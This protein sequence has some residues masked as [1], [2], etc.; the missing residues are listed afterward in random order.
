[1]GKV[2]EPK[3]SYSFCRV[4]QSITTGIPIEV[5]VRRLANPYTVQDQQNNLFD[6][7]VYHEKTASFD[8]D[9]LPTTYHVSVKSVNNGVSLA[10]EMVHS[11]T[12]EIMQD[13]PNIR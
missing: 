11:E 8:Q 13:F 6:T 3:P 7:V 10:K 2:R 5:S 12:T 4:A 9:L 1:M